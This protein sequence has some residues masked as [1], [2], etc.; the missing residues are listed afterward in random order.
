MA[1]RNLRYFRTG[2]RYL[3]LFEVE[4][5][6]RA[7]VIQEIQEGQDRIRDATVE[8][9]QELIGK[10]DAASSNRGRGFYA[11]RY[12]RPLSFDSPNTEDPYILVV[13]VPSRDFPGVFNY[14][15]EVQNSVFNILDEGSPTKVS[16]KEMRFPKYK[17]RM[18]S[19]S[20]GN[21]AISNN[22]TIL[23]ERTHAKGSLDSFVQ[24]QGWVRIPA[25]QTVKGFKGRKLYSHV[26]R[27]V[28]AK[29]G[30]DSTFTKLDVVR[31][32]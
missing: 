18:T 32:A 29:L 28:R 30:L 21:L 17:G 27:K 1:R 9:L 20:A 6:L 13:P 15:I 19:G 3:T 23:D 26:A 4:K 5:E 25:G 8:A 7:T 31:R 16:Q 22:V 2:T 10:L 12:N 11:V 14:R 24:P